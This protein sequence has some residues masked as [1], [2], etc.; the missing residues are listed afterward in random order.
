MRWGDYLLLRGRVG[1]A[2][3]SGV[4]ALACRGAWAAARPAA[5]RRPRP[6]ASWRRA[7]ARE[8]LGSGAAARPA[9]APG[10]RFPRCGPLVGRGVCT[11]KSSISRTVPSVWGRLPPPAR[12]AGGVRQ[13]NRADAP[14]RQQAGERRARAWCGRRPV[15]DA[16][17]HPED[18]AA[19]E[20]LSPDAIDRVIASG[21][22]PARKVCGRLRVERADYDAWKERHRVR[23]RR[24][25]PMFVPPNSD[26]ATGSGFPADL[27]A[28]E[29]RSGHGA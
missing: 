23:P 7:P 19:L 14:A 10:G 3:S 25:G 9:V 15:C 24:G 28:V 29:E 12:A 27:Q 21:D 20:R 22:L 8:T 13:H 5:W 1:D 4:V 17:D 11:P 26:R 6:R 18:I 16:R 2:A